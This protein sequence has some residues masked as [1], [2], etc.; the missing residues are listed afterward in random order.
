MSRIRKSSGW[1]DLARQKW[2]EGRW[3][4]DSPAAAYQPRAQLVALLL[5]GRGAGLHA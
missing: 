5:V 4:E 3:K 2:A 1:D